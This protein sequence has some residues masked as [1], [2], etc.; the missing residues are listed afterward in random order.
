MTGQI[1]M[2]NREKGF[3]FIKEDGDNDAQWFFHHS[4]VKNTEVC[5]DDEVS[6]DEG[7]SIR[8]PIAVNVKRI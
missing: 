6:F 4:Q 7:E 1:V 2:Y 3:G 5:K 8:G